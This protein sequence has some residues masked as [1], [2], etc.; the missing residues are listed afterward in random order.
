VR[1]GYWLKGEALLQAIPQFDQW[2]CPDCGANAR[3]FLPFDRQK[4]FGDA[5]H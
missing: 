2:R 1:C 4:P 3:A 5:T